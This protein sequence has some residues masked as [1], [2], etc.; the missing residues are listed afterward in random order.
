MI[1]EIAKLK[2]LGPDRVD[3][4]TEE[5]LAGMPGWVRELL[6]ST[7]PHKSRLL[8][9]AVL[10]CGGE[11]KPPAPTESPQLRLTLSDEPMP[12]AEPRCKVP[13]TAVAQWPRVRVRV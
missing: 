2:A 13:R 8:R 10:R 7:D 5:A 3:A 11:R 12:P 1:D 4:L 9:V 6:S